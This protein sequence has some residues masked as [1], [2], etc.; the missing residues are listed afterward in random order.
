MKTSLLLSIFFAVA[1]QGAPVWI[2]AGHVRPADNSCIPGAVWKTDAVLYNITDTSA[3]VRF[4]HQSNDLNWPLPSSVVVPAS[5]V[6]ALSMLIG[7][8]PPRGFSAI[9][10]DVPSGIRIENR[11]EYRYENPCTGAQPTDGPVGKLDLNITH[12]LALAGSSQVH[13]GTDLGLQD[14]RINVG[15]YNAADAPALAHIEVHI[16]SASATALSS[17]DAIVPADTLMQFTMPKVTSRN[18]DGSALV[19]RWIAYTTVTVSQPSF[20]YVVVNSNVQS[21][22]TSMSIGLAQ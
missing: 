2:L 19:P 15:I 18:Y 21:P 11:L 13:A 20:S 8:N 3:E 17:L 12:A 9:T 5:Q 16:P 1:L 6:V 7:P 22:N 10:L 14:A 4:L